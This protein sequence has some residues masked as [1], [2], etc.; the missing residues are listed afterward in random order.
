MEGRSDG[1][2]RLNLGRSI[3]HSC[4]FSQHLWV[5]IVGE[6][7]AHCREIAVLPPANENGASLKLGD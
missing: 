5:S 7:A 2:E 3:D 1:L 6:S 4:K